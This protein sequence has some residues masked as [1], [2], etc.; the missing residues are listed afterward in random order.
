MCDLNE[1]FLAIINPAA[2][3]GRCRQMVGA[4][5]ARLRA[6]G[7]VIEAAETNAAGEAAQIAREAYRRGCRKFLAVGGDGTSYEIVNGLFPESGIE[8][9]GGKSQGVSGSEDERIPTLG[10]LPLGSLSVR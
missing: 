4:A 3:G 7:I 5:L 9:L 10:F 8:V 2:G 1:T 6:A